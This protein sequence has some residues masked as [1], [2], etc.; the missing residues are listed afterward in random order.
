[1]QLTTDTKTPVILGSYVNAY[2]L[3]RSFAEA[4]MRSIVVAWKDELACH[5]RFAHVHMAP[6]PVSDEPAF[7]DSLIA[8]GKSLPNGG[9]ILCTDDATVSI[10]ARNTDILQEYYCILGSSWEVLSNCVDKR[11]MYDAATRAGVTIPFTRF[12]DNAESITQIADELPYPCMIKPSVTVGFMELLGLP[13]RT[14]PI[15]DK[16][17]LLRITSHLKS[18]GLNDREYVVQEIIPGGA[19]SLYTISAYCN[20]STQIIAY[21][22]GHKIRQHPPDAGTIISGRVV[23]IPGLFEPAQ[24]LVSELGF[25]GICNIEFKKDAQTGEFKLIE[26]NARPGMWNYSA[27]ASGINLAHIAYMDMVSNEKQP[28]PPSPKELVWVMSIDDLWKSVRYWKRNGYSGYSIGLIEW[29]RSL[30]GK[31]VD[32][33]FNAWDIGPWLFLIKQNLLKPILNKLSRKKRTLSGENP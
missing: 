18:V 11:P 24:R 22:I 29:W 14:I 32:P 23:P 9:F 20:K 4:G 1:M 13:G 28:V 17:S 6:D 25:Q 21:S 5:S 30:H 3:V 27:T 12:C 31:K 2:G 10:T 26:I 19:E 16:D 8:L 15:Q 7:V 33:V